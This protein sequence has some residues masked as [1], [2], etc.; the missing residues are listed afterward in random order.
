MFVDTLIYFGFWIAVLSVPYYVFVKIN[1]S[2][3]RIKY[4]ELE[5]NFSFTYP[6]KRAVKTGKRKVGGYFSFDRRNIFSLWYR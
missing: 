1:L 6:E 5:R 2:T 4:R 3:G